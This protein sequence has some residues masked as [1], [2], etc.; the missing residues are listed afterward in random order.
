MNDGEAITGAPDLTQRRKERTPHQAGEFI[1]QPLGGLEV[2]R[3]ARR[4]Q[5]R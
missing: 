2:G 1:E 4:R 3:T 5:N